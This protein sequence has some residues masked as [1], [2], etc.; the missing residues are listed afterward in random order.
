MSALPNAAARVLTDPKR[1]D[2]FSD[3]VY[4][5]CPSC[6]RR[7]WASERRFFGVLGPRALYAVVFSIVLGIVALGVYTSIF[8]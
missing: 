4:A 5:V 8:L 7:D 1:Y 3:Y 2:S 6:G